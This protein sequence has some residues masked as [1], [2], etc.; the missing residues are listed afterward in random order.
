MVNHAIRHQRLT[1]K[2]QRLLPLPLALFTAALPLPLALAG[3]GFSAT[4]VSESR[5][6]KMAEM[7]G[8]PCFHTSSAGR[9]ILSCRVKYP[10]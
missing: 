2:H 8:P 3:C 9:S 5:S 6:C 4:I 7:T 1:L 10:S